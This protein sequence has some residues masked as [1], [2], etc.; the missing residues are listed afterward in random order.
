MNTPAE[1]VRER[2]PRLLPARLHPVDEQ[3]CVVAFGA[4]EVGSIVTDLVALGVPF[5]LDEADDEL[6]E[7]LRRVGRWLL[8]AQRP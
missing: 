5:V 4:D 6:R 3:S 2:L 8:D 7:Q 1:Q